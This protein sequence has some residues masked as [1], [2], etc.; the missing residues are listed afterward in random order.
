MG[1][2]RRALLGRAGRSLG[3]GMAASAL[4]SLAVA[5]PAFAG[6]PPSVPMPLGGRI[7]APRGWLDFVRRHP[8]LDPLGSAAARVSLSSDR[9]QQLRRVQ[10]EVNDRILVVA[11]RNERWSPAYFTGDCE[12]IAIRKLID[13]TDQY[14]W[15]RGALMLSVCIT[16][17]GQ[18]HALLLA[19]TDRGV[20]ALDN[21]FRGV[22]PWHELP[23]IW[24]GREE[25]GDGQRRWRRIKHRA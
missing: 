7:K 16:E 23:Y 20:F 17:E 21:R 2:T 14:G 6:L 9:A 5:T 1:V 15:P 18:G 11:D 19:E 4:G 24:L 8:K 3:V 10:D 22:Q 25:P 13:L 12:D